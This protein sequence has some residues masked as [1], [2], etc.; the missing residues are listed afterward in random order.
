M[1]VDRCF[2]VAIDERFEEMVE[3][4]LGVVMKHQ[5]DAQLGPPRNG[6]IEA[7][8][9]T[10]RP[11]A[12]DKQELYV[13][14]VVFRPSVA[15]LAFPPGYER[16][17]FVQWAATDADDRQLLEFGV[18]GPAPIVGECAALQERLKKAKAET[19][20]KEPAP[21]LFH[22]PAHPQ[23][24]PPGIRIDGSHGVPA[25]GGLLQKRRHAA[26]DELEA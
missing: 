20:G 5:P 6:F 4:W 3:R 11:R 23:T 15:D 10:I 18:I 12:F 7:N 8:V 24:L 22:V 16:P 21:T 9:P 1:M 19:S 13:G 25:P 2:G 14:K 26:A 17:F